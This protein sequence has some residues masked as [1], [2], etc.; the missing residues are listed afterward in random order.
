MTQEVAQYVGLL[1]VQT[2]ELL[3]LKPSNAARVIN[4]ARAMKQQVNQ[5]V[6]D[7]TAYLVDVATEQGIKTLH[8]GGETITIS[9]GPTVEYDPLDLREALEAAG[10][11]QNRID[12]AVVAEI[13]YKVDRSVLRQLAAANPDYKAA[14]SLA[15]REVEKPYRATIKLR[16]NTDNAE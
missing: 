1:D 4:A 16:R 15:E 3:P 9:G 2:G 13:T 14:I 10:C 5:I 11:P 6:N 12:Q 7:A 8:D